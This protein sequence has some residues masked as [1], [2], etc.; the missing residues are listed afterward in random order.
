[1]AKAKMS[2]PFPFPNGDFAEMM[3][4]GKFAGQ[5]KLPNVDTKVFIEGHKRNLE[6]RTPEG[7]RL[8][9]AFADGQPGSKRAAA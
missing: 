5:F 4:F 8:G 1:M 6:A 3:D 9:V 7:L 2:T